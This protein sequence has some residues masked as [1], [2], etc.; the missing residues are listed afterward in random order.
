MPDGIKYEDSVIERV[1]VYCGA[2]ILDLDGKRKYPDDYSVDNDIDMQKFLYF[3]RCVK[4]NPEICEKVLHPKA[5][6]IRAQI[7]EKSLADLMIWS[8]K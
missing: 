6:L 3:F 7:L 8:L 2:F 4:W 1:G 5:N